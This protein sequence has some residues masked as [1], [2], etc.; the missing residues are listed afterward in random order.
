MMGFG[1]RN[2]N[3]KKCDLI[4]P[5]F[6]IDE[7]EFVNNVNCFH[8][9]LADKFENHVIGY[10]FKTNSFPRLLTIA[11][12]CNCMAEVVSE[13]EYELAKKIGFSIDNIIY[14]GP[15]KSRKSFVEAVENGAVVNIDSHRELEWIDDIDYLNYN[16]GLRVNFDLERKIPGQTS[17]GNLGGRFGFCYENGEL[18]QAIECLRKKRKDVN[19]LHMHVSNASKSTDVYRELAMMACQ[20]IEEE[21]LKLK[22]LDFG[23][24]FFGGGDNGEH[25]R[26]YVETIYDVLHSNKLDELCIIVEPGASVIATAVSYLTKVIDVK[27]TTYGRFV[28]S[29]GTRLDIDPFMLKSKYNF[30]TS[31]LKENMCRNQTVCGYTC[32]EKDRIMSI[33][34]G[35]ELTAGDFIEYKTVGSYTMGFNNMF[36]CSLPTVYSK[37][38]NTYILVRE[39]WGID[40]FLKKNRWEI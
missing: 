22:Y 29:D 37:Y 34:N 28:F 24:G 9:E 39:K 11:K 27:D 10:S 21:N 7:K 26:G 16:I 4:T 17:T 20:I 2:K 33:E 30:S 36:I 32:M 23:G 6:I 38:G 14:N 12:D 13:D 3:M 40:E 8:K 35:T 19:C 18:S 5:C 25:Y 31:C 15:I 1:I